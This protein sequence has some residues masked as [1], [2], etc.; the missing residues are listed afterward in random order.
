MTTESPK[1]S[2][3]AKSGGAGASSDLLGERRFL[4]YTLRKE[5]LKFKEVGK[6]MN[7]G[8][9]RARQLY[10]SAE[11]RLNREPHWTDGLGVRP[12]NCLWNMNI[13]SREQALEA[14]NSGRLRP[15][16]RGPRN[17]GWKSHKEVAKWL[18]LPEPQKH[19]PRVY[20]AKTCPHCGG[21]LS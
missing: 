8:A 3:E 7:V 4:A 16:K 14:Y 2:D 5:G 15:G 6:R 10:E 13:E 9:Q 19:A 11:R 18:G 20:L 1:P 17:Y 12:A 21:K